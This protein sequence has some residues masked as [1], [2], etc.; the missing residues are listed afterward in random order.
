MVRGCIWLIGLYF[1]L[2][3]HN[4]KNNCCQA[5]ICAGA[6]GKK[7][8]ILYNSESLGHLMKYFLQTQ[9]YAKYYKSV[10]TLW[11]HHAKELESA[12]PS[13]NSLYIELEISE[14]HW[15]IHRERFQ[16]DAT[17]SLAPGIG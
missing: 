2:F 10:V 17:A 4:N 15:R 8:L 6:A 16:K 12:A 1:E 13:I 7:D 5:L 14:Y 3:P 9:Q 11:G